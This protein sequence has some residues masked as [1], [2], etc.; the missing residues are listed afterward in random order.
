MTD[1]EIVDGILKGKTKFFEILI[2]R[3]QIPIYNLALKMTRVAED[4]E[5]LTQIVF[6]KAYENLDK[7]LSNYKFFSWLYRI[8]INETL[9]YINRSKKNDEIT[10]SLIVDRDDPSKI[11]DQKELSNKI[12][13][14]IMK[15]DKTYSE[16]IILKHFQNFSYEEISD[17]L[18]LD[19]KKVKSRLYSGRQMLKDILSDMGDD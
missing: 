9:N 10:D 3:Y 11:L 14:A 7:Y 15:L 19:L 4:A 6:V 2:D 17:M 5:D 13:K 8:G 18:D 1:N 12:N 16:L